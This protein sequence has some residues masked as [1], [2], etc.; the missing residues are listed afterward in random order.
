MGNIYHLDYINKIQRDN[1]AKLIMSN[2]LKDWFNIIINT[3]TKLLL[4]MTKT[5]MKGNHSGD[6]EDKYN[7]F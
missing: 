1:S 2:E 7:E 3:R 5:R 6:F 4:R